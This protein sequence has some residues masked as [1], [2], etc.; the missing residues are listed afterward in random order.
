MERKPFKIIFTKE[1]LITPSGLAIVGQMLKKTDL[2]KRVNSLGKPKNYGHRNYECVAGYIGLLCQG[3]TVY[4]DLREMQEDPGF[5]CDALGIESIPSAETVRQRLDEFGFDLAALPL[6]MEEN[7]KLLQRCGIKPG[8]TS[9]GHA[10]LDVDVS[11]HDNSNTKKE[12]VERTYMGIDGYAPIYAYL[13]NEGYLANAELRE[14]GCHCQNGTVEFLRDTLA[15][16]KQITGAK[17]LVRMDSGNDS[18]ENLELFIEE[19]VDYLV[20]RNLRKERLDEWLAE[21]KLAVKE[22]SGA[23]VS[24]RP[25]KTV[26]TGSVLRKR[27]GVEAPIRAVFQVTERTSLYNGQML[28]VPDIDVQTWWTSLDD[29]PEEIF[30]LYRDHA[31]CEQ[32]HSEIKTDIGLERFPSGNFD[33]NAAI[34]RMAVLAYNILRAIGQTALD[35]STPLTRHE[36]SRLRAK[37][38]MQRLIFIAGHAISHARQKFLSLGRSNIWRDA[39][40]KVYLAFS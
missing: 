8:L 18:L 5:Y 26:Y 9:T 12:G 19:N 27:D 16:A 40:L 30:R 37:T 36:V 34:L 7:V 21:A 39:F 13:G 32:F 25:G 1:R 11:I 6:L 17:L 38:V 28:L 4:D 24:P 15:Y 23:S 22:G 3:K 31:V 33:T 14:G 29:P 20:K 10:A 2:R 35:G